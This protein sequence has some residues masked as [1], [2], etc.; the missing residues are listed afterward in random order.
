MAA[1]AR[2]SA[3][4]PLPAALT[5]QAQ[6]LRAALAANDA[7]L[8]RAAASEAAGELERLA[9]RAEAIAVAVLGV[10]AMEGGA[11]AAPEARS[12]LGVSRGR[13]GAQ[14]GMSPGGEGDRPFPFRSLVSRKFPRTSALWASAW[15]VLQFSGTDL[16][17]RGDL[18]GPGQIWRIG[19]GPPRSASRAKPVPASKSSLSA[20]FGT[21]FRL[22]RLRVGDERSPSSA[23]RRELHARH[24][25][26]AAQI[27]SGDRPQIRI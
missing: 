9:G 8:L 2:R 24:T 18:G 27:D 5:R 19:S 4:E 15:T 7:A 3:A 17:R 26:G 21:N 23:C 13:G 22:V 16:S 1:A 6:R 20:D 10:G 12:N 11:A 14:M 25:Q